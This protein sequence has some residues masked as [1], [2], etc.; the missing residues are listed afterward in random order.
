MNMYSKIN[1]VTLQGLQALPVNVEVDI[2]NNSKRGQFF[3]VGLA[4]ATIQESK[5]RIVTALKNSG[6]DMPERKITVNLSP[7]DLKKEGSLFD[8]PIALGILH[9]CGAINCSKK[10]L[11]DSIIFGELSLD[12]TI[13]PIKGAL[14]ISSNIKSSTIIL[15]IDNAHEAALI[16]KSNIIG[17]K[18]LVE[19]V[20]F[21]TS[22][23]KIPAT[24]TDTDSFIKSLKSNELDF[25]DVK[26]QEYAKRALQIS[27]AGRHNFLFS[28]PPGSGKT[29]LAKRI[30]TI[31]PDMNLE[32]IIDTTKIYSISGK[33]AGKP[34]I[35]ERPFRSPH[36]STT[37][38]SLIGGG[39]NP[40]PGEISLANNG[41]LFLDEI[42]EF[43][44]ETLESLRE[45]L[46]NRVVEISRLGGHLSYPASFLLIAAYNP[47]PCGFFGDLKKKCTCSPTMIK[48]YQNKLSGPLLDRIDIRIGV[49]A[50]EY[51]EAIA[52]R[53]STPMCSKNLKMGVVRAM[54]TQKIRF[55]SD[56]KYNATMS[57]QDI[58]TYCKLTDESQE[59][60][61]KSFVKL[62]LSMRAY[63]KVIKLAQTIAD[64]E[65]SPDIK[66]EHITEALMYK[67]EA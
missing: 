63:H 41:V 30:L 60:I 66:P 14:A 23:L 38:P 43:S 65:D 28:G 24:K 48:H 59:I 32:E 25:D 34:L 56:V 8:L 53:E 1:S 33:L 27:A 42:T 51:E 40:Q 36:H 17:V 13:N 35:V 21:L 46:E 67:F 44:R 3:I 61:K 15:P 64:I 4:S 29:M 31:L 7:A 37:R 10:K 50:I 19:A 52:K 62:N 16:K 6:Y 18:T 54:E 57:A 39:H 9:A 49:R 2:D 11:E 47:C 26:G 20:K 5:K 12:G 58:E 45:P 55:G 22:E